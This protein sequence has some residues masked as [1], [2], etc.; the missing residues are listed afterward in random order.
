LTFVVIYGKYYDTGMKK[1]LELEEKCLEKKN[2]IIIYSIFIQ[3]NSI[4]TNVLVSLE[5]LIT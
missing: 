4:N 5:A 3:E 2:I 1:G